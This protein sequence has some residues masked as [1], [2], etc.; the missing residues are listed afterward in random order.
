MRTPEHGKTMKNDVGAFIRHIRESAGT[1][2]HVEPWQEPFVRQY[3]GGADDNAEPAWRPI[4]LQGPMVKAI[5]GG[6]KTQTRCVVKLNHAGR[7]K[8]IGG[9][10]NWHL[11]D[12]ECVNAAPWAPGD[13]LWVREK[14]AAFCGGMTDCGEEW[15]EVEGPIREWGPSSEVHGV[16]DIEYAADGKC[17]PRRWRSATTMPRWA[18]R[19]TLL[20]KSVRVERLQEISEA[21]AATEGTKCEHGFDYCTRGCGTPMGR[22]IVL[23]DSINAKK[24]P[25]ASNPWVWATEFEK[26]TP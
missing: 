20:V 12:P 1:P 26:I 17:R 2:L 7:V 21:D 14:F 23:W 10:R 25:W 5:L 11:G 16:P 4:V 3:M 18:S 6:R 9:H 15:D 8:E 19:I 24:H 22:F 13:R